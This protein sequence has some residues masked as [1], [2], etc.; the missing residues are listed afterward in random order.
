MSFSNET[1]PIVT[2]TLTTG[3]TMT[4]ELYPAIAP[5]SVNN[6]ISLV[7]AGFY[8]GLIFHRVIRGFMLQGGCPDGTGMGGPGYSIKGEFS[9]NGVQNDLV[10]TRGVLS[11]A[12][13]MMPNSAGS[14]FF[15]MHKDSPHLDGQYAAF[16]KI[17]DGLEVVDMIA[18]T[19]CNHNDKPVVERKIAKMTVDTKG[20]DYPA[21]NKL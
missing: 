16:G 6:F 17:T 2:I 4:L 7:Q 1:N 14:Q 9:G 5:E 21:P 20:V 8:D 3:E 11:M 15:I 12:R 19:E 10:H 18:E 13:S